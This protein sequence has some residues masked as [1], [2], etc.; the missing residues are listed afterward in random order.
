MSDAVTVSSQH[1]VH[2]LSVNCTNYLRQIEANPPQAQELADLVSAVAEEVAPAP[3]PPTRPHRER[4]QEVAAEVINEAGEIFAANPL[5]SLPRRA[6]MVVCRSATDLNW[7]QI[8]LAHGMRNANPSLLVRAVDQ[9]REDDRKFAAR[10]WELLE[11]GLAH[12]AA[13]GYRRAQF[14]RGLTM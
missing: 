9:A 6:S 13:A 8:A 2:R 4:M 10:F 12:R 3:A 7:P 5:E 14:E 1:F 11:R